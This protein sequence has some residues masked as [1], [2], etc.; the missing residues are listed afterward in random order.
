MLLLVSALAPRGF[1]NIEA[2]SAPV[3][4]D[5]GYHYD[6]NVDTSKQQAHHRRL[7]RRL[8]DKELSEKLGTIAIRLPGKDVE[9]HLARKRAEAVQ[10]SKTHIEPQEEESSALNATAVAVRQRRKLAGGNTTCKNN[11]YECSVATGISPEFCPATVAASTT[12]LLR[13]DGSFAL[14]TDSPQFDGA[15]TLVFTQEVQAISVKWVD[16][17]AALYGPDYLPADHVDGSDTG[18]DD[19]GLIDSNGEELFYSPGFGFYYAGIDYAYY[20]QDTDIMDGSGGRIGAGMLT[21]N[22]NVE[23]VVSKNMVVSGFAPGDSADYVFLQNPR[24][25]HYRCRN[26]PEWTTDGCLTW[27]YEGKAG[28][29]TPYVQVNDPDPPSPPPPSPSPPSPSPPPPS[30]SP[31]PPSPSPPP[32]SPSPPPPPPSPPPCLTDATAPMILTAN[33]S[34]G[35]TV[36]SVEAHLCALNVGDVVIVGDDTLVA[37]ARTV[38]SFASV[39]VTNPLVNAHAAGSTLHLVSA[40]PFACGAGTVLNTATYLCEIECPSTRR[41][42]EDS[43]EPLFR[44]PA[45]A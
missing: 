32:P 44:R 28:S 10:N 39:V 38:A 5:A 18:V 41:L 34:A 42:S 17:V 31:P 8:F 29:G 43:S 37:E 14:N 30:P 19:G 33:V 36:L 13:P 20:W 16:V 2:E 23:G 11:G 1:A 35:D 25:G 6:S 15:V 9:A 3:D 45:S 27:C 21:S 4:V 26:D 7:A 24:E 22:G 40:V 12:P